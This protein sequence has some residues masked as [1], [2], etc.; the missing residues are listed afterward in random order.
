M[1]IGYLMQAGAANMFARPLSGPGNHVKHVCQELAALGHE[2]ELL[3]NLDGQLWHSADLAHYQP[4][5]VARMERGPLKLLQ[6]VVRR[7]QATL[8]LP[9]AALFEAAWFAQACTQ[10]L[11]DCDL[12]YERMGWMGYGGTVAARHL[13]LPLVLE[14]NG[15]HLDEM[16]MLG[17]APHGGQK[18]LSL[19][20][21]RWMTGRAAHVVATGDGWR[22]RFIER[23][24]V[25]AE[26]VSTVENG[27]ELVTLLS[28]DQLRAFAPQEC[29]ARVNLVYVGGFE[30]WHGIS[31]LLRALAKTR[32]RGASVTLT[33][34]GAGPEQATIERQIQ[35]LQLQADVTLTGFVD[36]QQ[37]ASYL[38]QADIGLCPYC[39]RIEYS[40]LKL[41]DYKAAGLATIA[42]G[43]NGQPVVVRQGVTG[44]IVP[45]CDEEQLCQAII[46]LSVEHELRRQM[47][48]TARAEA[49]E[50]H[51]W[52]NTAQQIEAIF[53]QVTGDRLPYARNRQPAAAP[54][55]N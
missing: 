43:A 46:K 53:Q 50:Q 45:P 44:L 18:W 15:D 37:L 4:V 42:S 35:E 40:G 12:F 48:R 21:M 49:E 7:T 29:N 25:R 30:S 26:T 34:I 17:M 54:V 52:R 41:L 33:L 14:I 16:Q 11:G 1:K 6:R 27:S 22:R 31:V 55:A 5:A 23:W 3:M 47:G 9:Y 32:Q 19:W 10:V 24:P 51:S 2:V 39:G 8:Q 38:A 28:R 36:I 13:K 20:L